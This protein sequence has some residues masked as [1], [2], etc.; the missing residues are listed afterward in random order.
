MTCV[1]AV[2]GLVQ[3]VQSITHNLLQ[4]FLMCE[5]IYGCVSLARE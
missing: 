5:I 3:A 1:L 4:P 2:Y